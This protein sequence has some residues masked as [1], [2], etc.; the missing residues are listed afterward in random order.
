MEFVLNSI[1]N[2]H[3]VLWVFKKDESY[4][5]TFISSNFVLNT[6]L[7]HLLNK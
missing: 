3:H 1:L 5:L 4:V 6:I 2:Y 7:L